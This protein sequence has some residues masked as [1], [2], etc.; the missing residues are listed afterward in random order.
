MNNKVY[1]TRNPK[2]LPP[3][4]L[5][6]ARFLY[7]PEEGALI[8]RDG[9]RAGKRA[10]AP[11]PHGHIC[12]RLDGANYQASRIIFYMH[13]GAPPQGEIDHKDRDPSNNKIDNLRLATRR[14]NQRNR[15]RPSG[16]LPRGV[17]VSKGRYRAKIRAGGRRFRSTRF[18]TPEEAH[19]AYL[20]LAKAHHG[21]FAF[22]D[23]P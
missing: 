2:P 4:I 20:D 3:L 1:S 15:S 11:G 14:Q 8:W 16:K 7:L 23:A 22:C 19:K 17:E 5:L 21:D 10:G 13:H 18:K 12:V 6:E 9:P